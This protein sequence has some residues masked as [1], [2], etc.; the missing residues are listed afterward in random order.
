M[1]DMYR[2]K[3]RSSN[4]VVYRIPEMNVR[5]EFKAGQTQFVSSEEL[6]QL[7]YQPG[8]IAILT[9]FLQILDLDA[10]NAMNIRTEPEYHMSEA[11][12]HRLIVSGSLDE[13]LDALD[14]APIG[15]IDLIKKLS[16]T[17]PLVDISKRE[18]LKAKTGFDVESALKHIKE[19][20][21][22]DDN[23]L[24]KATG[25]RRVKPEAAPAGRRTTPK[26]NIIST[27]PVEKSTT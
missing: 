7:T 2:V 4:T 23:S 5:R 16:T 1:S 3:N 20:K 8:G 17:I 12:I 14:F 21:D 22:P 13:F 10:I 19:D 18:A 25:E 6:E 27:K 11:D 24:F 26:Y 15:V 9:Q